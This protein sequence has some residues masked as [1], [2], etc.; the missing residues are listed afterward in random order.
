MKNLLRLIILTICLISPSMTHA[1]NH[2]QQFFST[3]QDIPLMKGLTEIEEH[4]TSFDKPGGRII[5][6]YAIIKNYNEEDV[7]TYYNA[8]LPQFGWGKS[9][10]GH[11]YRNGEILKLSFEK[12]NNTHILKIMI[13]PSL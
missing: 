6:A 3:L 12:N 5:Q 4:A 1:Q 9:K 10:Q 7:M 2:D 8:T 13:S 11:Y